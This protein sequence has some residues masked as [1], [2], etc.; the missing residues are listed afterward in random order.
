MSWSRATSMPGRTRIS[1]CPCDIH[2]WVEDLDTGEF[3]A[4]VFDTITDIPAPSGDA[5]GPFYQATVSVS[6]LFTASSGSNRTYAVYGKL[7]PTNLPTT[8]PVDPMFTGWVSGMQAVYVPFTGDGSNAADAGHHR[9]RHAA[10]AR[11]HRQ[12]AARSARAGAPPGAVPAPA[13]GGRRPPG[14]G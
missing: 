1:V 7:I 6:H 10:V 3:S 11:R 12:P 4:A 13:P 2:A 5:T 8:P 14:A 9:L